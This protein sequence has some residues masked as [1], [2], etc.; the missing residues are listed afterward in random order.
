MHNSQIAPGEHYHIYSRGN[1]KQQLFFDDSDRIRFIFLLLHNQSDFFT[2][3]TSIH[4]SHYRKDSLFHVNK[5][6][7]EYIVS[8]KNVSLVNFC[9]MGNHF[10]ATVS[11]INEKGISKYMHRVLTAYS[12][13][14]SA[15]YK[16]KGHVF[17]SNFKTV[18]IKN[19]TQL[20]HLSSYI[21]RNP[22][23]IKEWRGKEN[24]YPWSTFQDYVDTNRWGDLLDPKI[25]LGGFG[26]K[27]EYKKFVDTSTAKLASKNLDTDHIDLDNL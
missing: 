7:I 8:N 13:Y 19:H 22:R 3:H 9:L 10:H 18:H 24:I 26:D 4:V 12:K 16:R 15:K 1:L 21:H 20:L 2:T 27:N 14:F 11:E 5:K 23:E 17:E 25:I 6:N